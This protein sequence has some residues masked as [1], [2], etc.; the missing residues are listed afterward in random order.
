M[1]PLTSYQNWQL[2]YFGTTNG[3]GPGAD[4]ADPDGDGVS[5]LMEYALGTNPTSAASVAH[6][7]ASIVNQHLS[8]TFNRAEAD[9]TYLVEVSPDLVSWT[10]I[11]T[12]PGSVGQVVTTVDPLT[13]SP[14]GPT[15]RFLRL[16][17]TRP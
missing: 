10:V 16:R 5:N 2:Q 13:L 15:K 4:A 7:S 1:Q 6:P 3:N 11:A 14:D 9:V 12:N 8:I 17:I